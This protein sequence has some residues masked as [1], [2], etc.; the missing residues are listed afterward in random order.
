MW[1]RAASMVGPARAVCFS[2][3]RG[4]GSNL[5]RR[6]RRGYETNAVDAPSTPSSP[7]DDRSLRTPLARALFSLSAMNA[8]QLERAAAALSQ[9]GGLFASRLVESGVGAAEVVAA[10]SKVSGLTP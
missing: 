4:A 10:L 7:N 1:G 3:K 2:C 9:Q 5:D 8:A 6:R